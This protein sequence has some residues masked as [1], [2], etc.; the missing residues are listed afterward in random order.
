MREKSPRVNFLRISHQISRFVLFR[1]DYVQSDGIF[2]YHPLWNSYPSLVDVLQPL[3][4]EVLV[5]RLLVNALRRSLLSYPATGQRTEAFLVN[6]PNDLSTYWGWRSAA[7]KRKAL[8]PK[9]KA[10]T[11]SINRERLSI[12]ELKRSSISEN[13]DLKPNCITVKEYL[14]N[15]TVLFFQFRPFLH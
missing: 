6:I 1:T 5:L 13:D 15:R 9:R 3:T 10:S 2:V 11:R 7:P 14:A 12:K 4:L 8:T